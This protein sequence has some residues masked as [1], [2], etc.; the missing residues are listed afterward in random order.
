MAAEANLR[1]DSPKSNGG[2]SDFE[3]FDQEIRQA[4][5][6]MR[7]SRT[8]GDKKLKQRLIVGKNQKRVYNSAVDKCTSDSDEINRSSSNS[9]RCPTFSG[10]FEVADEHPSN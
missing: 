5:H 9:S 4:V 7:G 8:T 2:M 10:E 6:H 1:A 3:E